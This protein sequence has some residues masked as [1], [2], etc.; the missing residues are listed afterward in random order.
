M[1]HPSSFRDPNGYIFTGKNGLC[2]LINPLY[3]PHFERLEKSGLYK[4]LTDQ[5]LLIPHELLVR[6][7]KKI[8]IKPKL[9]PFITYP[10][11]WSF[12][13]LKQAALLH[14]KINILSL[15]HNMAVKDASS[16]NIQFLGSK[17]IFIDTLSFEKYCEGKPWYGFAQFCRHFIAPLLLIKYCSYEFH[18]VLTH[19]IDGFPLDLTSRLLPFKTHFSPFIK[20][21]IHIHAKQIQKHQDAKDIKKEVY[22]S[23][24]SLMN[25]F[26]YMQDYLEKLKCP[27]Y[28]TEWKSYHTLYKSEYFKNK[29][30][31]VW[32]WIKSYKLQKIWDLAGNDGYLFRNISDKKEIIV[33]SDIDY[34]SIDKCFKEAH[35]M[36]KDDLW[37]IRLDITNPTPAFGF[38]NQERTSFLERIYNLKLDCTLVLAFVHHLCISN[39]CSYEKMAKMFAGFSKYLIIEFVDRKDDRVQRLLENMRDNKMLFDFYS[40]D[41]FEETFKRFFHIVKKQ[42]TKKP[43]RTLYLMKSL[44]FCS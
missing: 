5:K 38:E 29:C 23:K 31:V 40:Q 41:G 4:T 25:I 13:A 9:I 42:Q 20:S 27:D 22:L 16:Y 35:Q 30:E 43:Y 26:L 8:I 32:D 39:N 7:N 18:K 34:I 36:N 12:E 44:S 10:S 3:F 19:F 21:N 14:L 28:Q 15:E 6:D 1:Q 33:S 17:P 11:E 2:R 24:K 37:S